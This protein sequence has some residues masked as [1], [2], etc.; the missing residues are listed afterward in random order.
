LGDIATMRLSNLALSAA[1]VLSTALFATPS[2]AVPI[3]FDIPTVTIE[4]GSGYGIDL[5]ENSGTFLDVRFS[6]AGFVAQ[7]FSLGSVLAFH[8][9]LIG[10][11]N[12]LEPD[13]H[14]GIEALEL[15]YLGVTAHFT[16]QDPL[17]TTQDVVAVGTAIAGSVS[18]AAIDYTLVWTPVL[19][20]FGSTGQFNIA[21]NNL[22]LN[23]NPQ[24]GPQ[25]LN[26]T[27]TLV[28]D[29]VSKDPGPAQVPEPMTLSLLGAGL[30]G[31]VALRRRY[32]LKA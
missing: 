13:A 1:V 3:P 16:F 21:L 32:K 24:E 19:V 12:L 28:T 23:G 31:L 20:N 18:D 2:N 29:D 27:I 15:D 5:D 30:A 25:N 6:G 22:S 7:N 4:P 14:G 8:T 26:A 10:T 9:F 11:A 17:G